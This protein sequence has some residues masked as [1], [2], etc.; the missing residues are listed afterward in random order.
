MTSTIEVSST[1]NRSPIIFEPPSALVSATAQVWIAASGGSGGVADPNWGGANIWLS[2]DGTTYNQIGQ[3]VGPARQGVLSASMPV[4][5]GS[6]PD[7]ADALA[8]NLAESGGVLAN[9][10]ALDAQLANT[11][12]IVDSELVSYATATLTSANNYSLTY[13]YRGLYGTACK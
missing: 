5:S 3:I 9:A 13:L 8:V 7:T 11:L 12:C 2:I 4:F 6:N 10:T 1:T